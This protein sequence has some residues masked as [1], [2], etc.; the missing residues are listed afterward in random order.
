MQAELE[1]A[2]EATKKMYL[3]YRMHGFSDDQAFE[4]VKI[5]VQ[6]AIKKPGLFG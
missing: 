2:A 3:A 1:K 4:L 6:A 5:H